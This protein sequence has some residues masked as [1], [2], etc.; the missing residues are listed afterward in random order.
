MDSFGMDRLDIPLAST[1]VRHA[2]PPKM[3]DHIYKAL[4]LVGSS[5]TSIKSGIQNAISRASKPFAK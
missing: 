5:E 3:M 2:V 4:E 1:E